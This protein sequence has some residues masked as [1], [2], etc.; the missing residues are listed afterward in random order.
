MKDVAVRSV[1]AMMDEWSELITIYY[2]ADVTEEDAQEIADLLEPELEDADIE[3]T[4]GGQPVY[5]YIISVE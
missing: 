3:V 1:K 4:Y 2:G 5:Y